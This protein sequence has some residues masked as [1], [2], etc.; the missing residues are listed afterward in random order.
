MRPNKDMKKLISG[1]AL[2]TLAGMLITSCRGTGT[3][4]SFDV[5]IENAEDVGSL[6]IAL[7][8]DAAVIEITEVE[9][10]ELSKNALLEFNKDTA[11]FLT[12][13]VVDSMGIDG[14]GPIATV[15]YKVLQK[16]GDCPLR[17]IETQ[18][19]DTDNLVDIS[20]KLTDGMI[21]GGKASPPLLQFR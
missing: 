7:S 16:D 21:S 10:A 17:I 18:A 3:D 6:Q 15:S 5:M 19:F 20:M 9:A 12:I 8:Y 13:G 4:E 14:G 11:G 2:L 1:L